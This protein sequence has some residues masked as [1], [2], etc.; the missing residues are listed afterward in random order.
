MKWF[1]DAPPAEIKRE[2]V[3]DFFR[4]AYLSTAEPDP[5]YDEEMECYT[6]EMEKLLGRKFEPGRGNAKCLR[7]TLDK[8]KML[9]RSL[10][11]YLVSFY[12]EIYINALYSS[13]RKIAN[14][15][16]LFL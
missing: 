5:A 16:A 10:T 12:S 6:K 2:N 13:V 1:Q 9:H 8:V 3:K 14:S 7:L 11:W 4:W 15:R